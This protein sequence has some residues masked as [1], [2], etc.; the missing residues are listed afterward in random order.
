MIAWL[1]RLSGRTWGRLEGRGR[2]LTVTGAGALLALGGGMAWGAWEHIC[3]DCPSI[4]QIYAFEP[5]EATRVF[6][7]DGSVLHEFAIERRTTI[8]YAALPSY[9]P[10]AFI[11]IEDRR[12]WSHEGIDYLRS[13]RAALDFLLHGYDVPGGSTITQQLAGNMFQASVNRRERSVRRKLREMRV[14]LALERAYTKQEIL[15]AYLNQI[16]FDRVYGIQSAAMRYFGKDARD[17][18]L[19]EAA[20]LAALPRAP[21]RYSPLRNPDRA[22]QRRNLVLRLMADQGKVDREDAEAAMAYPL[23][24]RR[25]AEMIAEAPYFVEW[26]RQLLIERY[27]TQLYEAGLKVYTTLDP[28][29]Q[30]V[31]DSAL[32][33]QLE[34]IEKQPGFAAPTYA[35]T[36]GWS[37]EQLAGPEMP[38]VQGMFLAVDART[39]D[40]LAMIGGRDFEDSEF[41][42]A[43]QARRQ[44]GSAFKPFVYT[45]ALAA[46][47]PPSEVIFDTP[48]EFPQP[49]GTIWSPRNFDGRFSG[50]IT[51]REAFTRSVNVVAVKLGDRVGIETVAQYAHR[52]GIRTEIPRVPSTAIGAPDVIPLE[53]VEAYTTFANMGVRVRPRP[54]TRIESG[55]GRVLWESLVEREE[56]L[57]ERLS[58][59][60]LSMMQDVVNRGTAIRVRALG[61]PRSIPLA[62]KTGTTNEATDAWFVG[63][64]PE[65]VTATWVGFD[66]PAKIRRGAQGG[67]DAA[68]VNAE[69]FKWFYRDRP[70]PAPW[71]RPAGITE[72]RVDPLTGLLAGPWCPAERVYTEVYLPDT[73]PREACDLHGPWGTRALRDSFPA[74]SVQPPV[75]D[76]FDF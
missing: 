2:W 3:D 62:G 8:P 75:S 25:D 11:A 60:M 73:E 40:V 46:G 15:E 74:D 13:V 6:A 4:A 35:E 29:L 55:D 21:A 76:D 42:R 38:Y 54:I 14:A 39:G 58:W 10:D 69:V 32:R 63:F 53:L 57:D 1:R 28:A 61:V 68:P 16:N 5:K 72:R 66:A 19:P 59:I 67:R 34:W 23:A 49:D 70:P 71:P 47:I 18:N 44:P 7:R 36:R 56:V 24:I 9:V 65:L 22:V 52:M 50:P 33:A 17:L 30:A 51:M 31:A 41:N 27:G 37:E 48:I 12:F 26:V 45:A 64:T 43:W 20:L